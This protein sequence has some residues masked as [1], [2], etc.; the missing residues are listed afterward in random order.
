MK[1]KLLYAALVLLLLVGGGI[2]FVSFKVGQPVTAPLPPI[3]ANTSPEAVA[4]GAVIFHSMCEGCHR[5]P[6]AERVTGA[7][8]VEVPS[9]LGTFYSANIT[10][11][12]TAGIGTLSDE[13]IARI[14]RYGVNRDDRMTMMAQSAMSD[15]DIAAVLGFMRSGDPVFTPDPNQM[16]PTQLSL[17]GKILIYT[18]G[19][20][21][22]PNR[23][24]SGIH[25]PPRT[26]KLAYG[27]YLAHD[28]FDCA[29]CHT[30]GLDSKKGEGPEAFSGGFEFEDASGAKIV[31]P[32]ITF[33]PTGIGNW[34]KEDFGVAIRDGLK[35]GGTG[36]L[37][38]PMPRFRGLEDDEV[39]ALYEYLK[40]KP[41]L[42]TKAK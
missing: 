12:P 24:A 17:V 25:A 13:Q 38:M 32:N 18:M 14:I 30:P 23:P 6:G 5:A 40:S 19:G 42:A 39:E 3:K 2:G 11:H 27:R 36:I 22:V 41:Q 7:H 26:D 21:D 20:M 9:A 35:P 4:R 8:M 33:H 37:R 31:G 29:G 28:V 34:S 16:P 10:M 15:E 1:K